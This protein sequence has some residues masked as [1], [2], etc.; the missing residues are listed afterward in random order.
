MIRSAD[1]AS[2]HIPHSKSECMEHSGEIRVV[3]K[4]FTTAEHLEFDP[5]TYKTRPCHIASC[6]D[7]LCV[8]YHSCLDRRR[9]V[10]DYHYKWLPCKSVKVGSRWGDTSQCKFGDKCMFS[11]SFYESHYHPHVYKTRECTER[12]CKRGPMCWNKHEPVEERKSSRSLTTVVE[13]YSEKTQECKNF[14][15]KISEAN[16]RV[17][18]VET[19]LEVMTKRMRCCIC[20][21]R[22]IAVALSPCGNVFCNVC[23]N[24][25]PQ[26]CPFCLKPAKLRVDLKLT[27]I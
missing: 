7:A 27:P 16:A 21:R 2:G 5:M 14:K 23:I 6:H 1:A 11:H 13:L 18:Q 19:Q 10:N 26:R 20:K 25:N 12:F 3:E 22:P 8:F 17:A 24:A 9:N 15:A 4:L